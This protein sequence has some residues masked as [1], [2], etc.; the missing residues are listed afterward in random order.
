[1]TFK[2]RISRYRAMDATMDKLFEVALSD[3]DI[4]DKF[5]IMTHARR[6]AMTMPIKWVSEQF[7]TIYGAKI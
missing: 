2:Q 3:I 1:M 5:L 7:L 6:E 4:K